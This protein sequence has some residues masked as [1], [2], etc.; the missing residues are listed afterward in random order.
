MRADLRF[1]PQ[2]WQGREYFVARDPVSLRFY[3]FE[4]EEY[5]ILRMLDGRRSA[6]QVRREFAACFAPQKITPGELFQFI[7]SLYRSCLLISDAPGQSLRL[8]NREVRNRRRVRRAA[9]SGILAI[10]LRGF[11]PDGLLTWLNR[12]VGWIFSGP[13]VAACVTMMIASL[14]LLIVNF[15]SFQ[16]RL[17]SLDLFF[18]GGNWILLGIVLATTKVLHELG[19]G[20]ACKRMGSHCHGMG[21]MFLVLMPCLYCDVSDSWML[22][23]KWKRAAIAAAGM[24]VEFVLASLCVFLWWFSEPGFFNTVALNIVV[25]CSV[26]T[27]LFNANPL[28][29]Y[30]GYYILSDLIEVPNLRQKSSRV[31]ARAATR[32]GL[33]IESAPDPFMPVRHRWLFACYSLAAVAWRWIITLSIFWFLYRLLEPYGLRLVGQAIAVLALYGLV[34]TPLVQLFRFLKTPGRISTMKP[35]RAAITAGLVIAVLAGILAIPVPHEIRCGFV[36]QPRDASPVYVE[37]A[38]ALRRILVEPGDRV[39]VGQPLV[40]LASPDLEARTVSLEGELAIADVRHRIV[41]FQASFNPNSAR[42]IES[43]EASRDAVARQLEQHRRNVELM[44]VRAP[45]EGRVVSAAWTAREDDE[46]S[47]RLA[48]WYGHPLESRNTGAWLES[49]TIVCTIAPEGEGTEAILAIDQ[50]DIEFV[51]SGNDVRLWFR[52]SPGGLLESTIDVISPVEMRYVPRGLDSRRG[53]DLLT[54]TDEGG[55]DVPVST[56]YEV[57]VKLPHCGPYVESGATGLARVRT[58]HLTIGQRLW[59]L[60]CKTFRFDL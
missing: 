58:G 22:K 51:A 37:A 13:A 20:L 12:R 59:R 17:P 9:L 38:G 8:L 21:V 2:T 28:M 52:Q 7:G 47:G 5:A 32:W 48:A 33:G 49:G 30:D 31:L 4:A 11:D 56:T 18:S 45:I 29:R 39:V 44:T 27:L 42:E 14:A 55:R 19:H 24:Y 34:G 54:T 26:S 25:V 16:A 3:R 35:S 15:E 40:Q 10:R 57:R 43:A 36:T 53:G 1:V 60:A 23:S 6:D 41:A 50:S 46:Q